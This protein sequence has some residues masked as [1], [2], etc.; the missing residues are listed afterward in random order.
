MWLKLVVYNVTT[1]FKNFKNA[2]KYYF[3]DPEYWLRFTK[4]P[5][6][7]YLIQRQWQGETDVLGGK[8]LFL[9]ISVRY[10]YHVDFFFF[11]VDK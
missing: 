1:R 3:K 5:L 4:S 9:I 6:P 11:S 7:V 8:A 2:K 10:K